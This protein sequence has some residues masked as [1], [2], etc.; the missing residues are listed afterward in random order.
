MI[1][2]PLQICCTVSVGTGVGDRVGVN[3]GRGGIGVAV[4]CGVQ[5]GGRVGR[6]TG[7]AEA[8]VAATNVRVGECVAVA[9]SLPQAA[10]ST[11]S[12]RLTPH[13]KAPG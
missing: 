3:V 5:L 8:I 2:N 12:R 4:G 6:S 9:G 11:T 1:T 7:M 10:S 13:A